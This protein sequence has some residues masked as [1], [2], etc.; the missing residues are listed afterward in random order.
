MSRRKH[1]S[2]YFVI[3]QYR[4][5]YNINKITVCWRS[6]CLSILLLF[7][8]SYLCCVPRMPIYKKTIKVM[9]QYK[10]FDNIY[11]NGIKITISIEG[12]R[13]SFRISALLET[14]TIKRG[15]CCLILVQP[16]LNFIFVTFSEQISMGTMIP[17][18][19]T[20]LL[21]LIF[22]K[23]ILKINL[24]YKCFNEIRIKRK[25]WNLLHKFIR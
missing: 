12:W 16:N 14:T 8:D 11:S 7:Q 5:G 20:L 2:R 1:L 21:C 25:N 10:L 15:I 22:C 6:K 3:V 9:L 24:S 13:E 4:R 23:V 18:R 17:T 19:S